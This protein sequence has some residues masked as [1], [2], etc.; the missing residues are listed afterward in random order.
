MSRSSGSSVSDS[1]DTLVSS[2]ARSPP[3][4]NPRDA[5]CSS[6]DDDSSWPDLR[7]LL[8]LFVKN[9]IDCFLAN[10]F[11]CSKIVISHLLLKDEANLFELSK[12]RVSEWEVNITKTKKKFRRQQLLLRDHVILKQAF[13]WVTSVTSLVFYLLTKNIV[14]KPYH[15]Q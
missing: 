3:A 12:S 10:Y 15:C 4:V 1:S 11:I 6:S 9:K 7:T 2:R 14:V 5:L 8:E 13:C